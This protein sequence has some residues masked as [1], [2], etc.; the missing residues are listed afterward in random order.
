MLHADEIV[1]DV[2]DRIWALRGQGIHKALE[3]GVG[4][5]EL[6]EERLYSSY[7]GWVVGGQ[8]DLFDGHTI[9]DYKDTSVWSLR[10]GPKPEWGY[11]QQ[12]LAQL[13]RDNGFDPR[14]GRVVAFARDWRPGEAL[15]YGRDY[16]AKVM[17]FPVELWTEAVAQEYM[18]ARVGLH[19]QDPAPPCTPSERWDRPATWAVM[20]PGRKSALR[21]LSTVEAAHRW[22]D[23]RDESAKL[24]IVYRSGASV[25]CASYCSVRQWCEF[26]SR[27]TDSTGEECI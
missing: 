22:R 25:R 13:L 16:P 9:T 2:S 5:G 21:V 24:E 20:R 23:S 10:G 1:E 17:V 27:L 11:Q 8:F 15:R 18:A 6:A 12:V 3:R 4:P 19:R 7:G 14:L 26:G